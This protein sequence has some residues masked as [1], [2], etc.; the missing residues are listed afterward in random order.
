MFHG[1]PFKD[2][3]H[4]FSIL[5]RIG[6]N[7]YGTQMTFDMLL[8]RNTDRLLVVQSYESLPGFGKKVNDLTLQMLFDMLFS[9]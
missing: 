5:Q 4:L 2:R 3:F 8:N 7:N 9:R 1:I 6:M